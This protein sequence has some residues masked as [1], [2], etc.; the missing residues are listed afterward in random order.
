MATWG[1]YQSLIQLGAAL[2]FGY[3]GYEFLL[4]RDLKNA[5]LKLSNVIDQMIDDRTKGVNKPA[6]T[7]A[8]HQQIKNRLDFLKSI[9]N[10]RYRVNG[11]FSL[12][13]GLVSLAIL[14]WLSLKSDILICNQSLLISFIFTSYGWFIFNLIV[15]GLGIVYSNFFIIRLMK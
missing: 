14:Y 6:L 15:I 11:L 9:N 10:V 13:S 2:N 4:D 8:I 7:G 3:A 5:D 12:I 1:S